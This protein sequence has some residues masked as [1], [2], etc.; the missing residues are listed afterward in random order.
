MQIAREKQAWLPFE[1][2]IKSK[3]VVEGWGRRACFCFRE[4]E[5][6]WSLTSVRFFSDPHVAY[7]PIFRR[8][9]KLL[10]QKNSVYIYIYTRF[11][12]GNLFT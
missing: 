1:S 12:E 8:K 5:R 11:R 9:S 6:R 2:V 10:S 3:E 7:K 4:Y